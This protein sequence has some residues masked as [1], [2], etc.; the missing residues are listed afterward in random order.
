MKSIKVASKVIEPSGGPKRKET[1]IKLVK[2]SVPSSVV[3]SR[4]VS[5]DDV[6][7]KKKVSGFANN[8]GKL[9]GES[10]FFTEEEDD[11]I[12]DIPGNG[13]TN[14]GDGTTNMNRASTH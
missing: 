8:A 9:A 6:V 10:D 4:C 12:M 7:R 1:S 3:T 13:L 14:S 5:R 2:Y 11:S